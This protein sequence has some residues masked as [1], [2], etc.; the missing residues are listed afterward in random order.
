MEGKSTN[1][2]MTLD[3]ETINKAEESMP[4]VNTEELGLIK[5]NNNNNNNNNLNTTFKHGDIVYCSFGDCNYGYEW[6]AVVYTIYKTSIQ[7]FAISH[8][9]HVDLGECPDHGFF[10]E[11]NVA[12]FVRPC[13]IDE[14]NY[15]R[16]ILEKD[17]SDTA[18]QIL[19]LYFDRNNAR[20]GKV[21]DFE[22]ITQQMV[23]L[24]EKK[25]HDYGDSFGETFRKLGP[26][27]AITRIT[28]KYNRLVSLATKGEQ[29]V[30]DEKLE[31]TL[32]DLAN[33]A[34]MTIMEIR[35]TNKNRDSS[36]IVCSSKFSCEGFIKV[37]EGFREFDQNCDAPSTDNTNKQAE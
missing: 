9:A 7:T 25:N 19:N 32:I 11:S 34:V 10:T 29:Q 14:I 13:T 17:G 8:I 21:N 23:S 12:T 30:N 6:L 4:I 24:Y 20:S 1:E 33:Y 27:S 36:N 16:S 28:D 2:L 5:I 31:D 15:F 37:G 3:M 22:G 18:K 26:I 35:N